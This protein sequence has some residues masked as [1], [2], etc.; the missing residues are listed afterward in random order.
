MKLSDAV[1]ATNEES[2]YAFTP[3]VEE[4]EAPRWRFRYDN[5]HN[6]PN[7]DILLLGAYRHPKTRNNLVGGVNLHYLDDKQR[8]QLARALPKIMAQG[9]LKS[10]YW[11]GR[12]L[13]PQVFENFY[14]TYNARF[15]RG[16]TKD[17][18]YP[19]YGYLK[20][21]GKWLKKKAKSFFK[22]K[23]QRA[24]AAE[25]KYP[26]D[27]EKM[28]DRLDQVVT[29]L[30]QE[31]P[32]SPVQDTPEMQ[33]ARD[34]FFRY[35]QDKTLQG[36]KRKEDVPMR[37]AEHDMET[38]QEPTEPEEPEKPDPRQARQELEKAREDSR[39]EL[40]R[41][42]N[43]VGDDD[44]D[45]VDRLGE[46]I[47]YYSPI[48]GRYIIETFDPTKIPEFLTEELNLNGEF[49][50][51]GGHA[52]E[53]SGQG[54]GDHS[55]FVVWH[56]QDHIIEALELDE[57][58][59][60]EEVK[61][62]LAEQEPEL[63]QEIYVEST[64]ADRQRLEALLGGYGITMEEWDIACFIGD[65]DPRVFAAKNYGWV[66]LADNRLETYGLSR[67]K[68]LSIAMGLGDAYPEQ[69]L[70]G[71]DALSRQHAFDIYCHKTGR[72]YISVPFDVIEHGD[73]TRLRD[74]DSHAI[75][76]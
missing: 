37:K 68:L 17:I 23:A 33:S 58:I 38:G 14:R 74:H 59:S 28:Q 6:D 72:H 49:W 29:Q 56:L 12:S 53:A 73:M 26:K 45:V 61:A 41:P 36:I 22:T 24:K 35:Q 69:D 11:E 1:I 27:L 76:G 8:D 43:E 64:Y 3:I 46:C 9:N 51:H 52:V 19:K 70:S 40:L 16:V 57:G 10:R 34:A 60:W 44:E 5:Y 63:A 18:M 32:E 20:T 65:T 75:P 25:P 50:L 62:E 48:A 39:N 47:S 4:D 21:A 55:T 7:P 30:Q 71:E 42:E 13:V 67:N 31:P 2:R 54:V 15:I 66:R